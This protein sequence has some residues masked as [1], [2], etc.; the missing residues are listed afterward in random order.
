MMKIN[1]IRSMNDI[2]RDMKKALGLKKQKR[3]KRSLL[4]YFFE[5]T[6]DSKEARIQQEDILRRG[7]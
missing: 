6:K 4:L 7:I 3:K 1:N 5:T 2:I